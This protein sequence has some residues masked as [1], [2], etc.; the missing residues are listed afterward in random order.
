MNEKYS[1]GSAMKNIPP[2]SVLK[3]QCIPVPPVDEQKIIVN[4]LDSEC[5]HIEKLITG[6]DKEL[7]LAQS[8]KQSLIYEYVTGK[9]RVKEVV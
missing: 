5:S 8:Y 3:K 1:N 6:K 2:F 7:K 4:R 9:K